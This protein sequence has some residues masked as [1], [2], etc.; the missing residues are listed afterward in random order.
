MTTGILVNFFIIFFLPVGVLPILAQGV[1]SKPMSFF[2]Y[3][4]RQ[5]GAPI[6]LET[7]VTTL[8][9]NRYSN[10]YF[11]G[12]L[13]LANGEAFTV[14]IQTKGKYRRKI[15]EI[16]PL[17]LKATKKELRE[18][19]LDTLTE[20]RLILPC[21]DSY[22][23]DVLLIKEYLVYRM[24]EQL[25]DRC[26]RARLVRVTLRDNHVEK[27][28]KKM[29]GLLVEDNEET[30]AR[31][32]G[33]L[34]EQYGLPMD[35]LDVEHTALMAIFQYMIGNTDWDLAMMRNVR[36]VRMP[37]GK[38]S[39]IPYDFDFAGLVAAPYASPSS[40]SG[41]RTV[42]DR[43]LM[44]NGIP[45][46][47]LRRAVQRIKDKQQAL[48]NLCYSRHLPRD[49]SAEMIQYLESFFRKVDKNNDVPP[50]AVAEVLD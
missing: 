19:S 24:F 7:D 28:S 37:D 2:E 25:T 8:R 45:R 18:H 41:L 4:G 3:V 50:R 21:Y 5:E 22:E 35:S 39:P 27:S 23:G 12:V 14:K 49:V 13:T 16:P 6:I 34:V 15:A 17:K 40:E 33:A 30:A 44:A 10:E 36:M 47:A 26:V 42:R 46:E 1:A 43:F 48:F 38:I 11:P 9:A 31:L 20:M 32:K 29:Y